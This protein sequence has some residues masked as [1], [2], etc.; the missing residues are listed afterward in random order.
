MT[1][2]QAV[3]Y[4]AVHGWSEFFPVSSQ[5]HQSLLAY[6]AGWQPPSG[7]LMTALL[8]G[9]TLALLGFFRHDWA[10]MISSVL[11]V[12]I[13]RKKPM[14]L[15]ERIPLFVGLTTLP[16]LIVSFY[17][18]PAIHAMEWSPWKVCAV[19]GGTAIPLWFFDYWGR[20]I[21]GM[22]D[23]NLLDALVV[24][25]TQA[26]ALFPGWDRLSGLLLGAFL[27]NYK[28]E[29]ALKYAY[30]CLFPIL[31]A[32][33]GLGLHELDFHAAMPMPDLSWLSFSAAVV[34]SCL[35]SLLAIGGA[36]RQIQQKG[37]GQL[38]FYRFALVLVVSGFLWF[39][40]AA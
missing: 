11:Q 20:K 34:V 36:T 5:A 21:K 19:L 13:Y 26:T 37:V 3:V 9:S 16:V 6:L 8:L 28:R 30:F 1:T 24:G 17:F 32:K 38:M 14:T 33:A 15:D 39:R 10:S 29:S 7:A 18:G 40:G 25:L 2:F 27:L 31:L 35:V 23:W 12:I 4:A 22:Y